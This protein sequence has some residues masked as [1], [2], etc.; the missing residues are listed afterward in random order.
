MSENSFYFDPFAKGLKI[1]L[2][3]TEAAIM[4]LIWGKKKL[5]VKKTVFFLHK[6]HHL[7]YTTVMTVMNRLEQKKILKREKDKR[8]FIYQAVLSK[9]D[10]IKEKIKRVKECLKKI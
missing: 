6:S 8:A 7:A 5:S 1:F 2:G 3:P 10:F 4:N 9:D